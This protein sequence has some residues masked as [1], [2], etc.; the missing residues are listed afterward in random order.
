MGDSS[1]LFV[2]LRKQSSCAIFSCCILLEP[3]KLKSRGDS[4]KLTLVGL[5]KISRNNDGSRE[6]PPRTVQLDSGR[7]VRLS[8]ASGGLVAKRS[9]YPLPTDLCNE[10]P[11]GVRSCGVTHL[12]GHTRDTVSIHMIQPPTWSCVERMG[13]LFT[14]TSS[15]KRG[16]GPGERGLIISFSEG[17]GAGLQG[18]NIE[19]FAQQMRIIM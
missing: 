4:S 11:C 2:G 6:R 16:G 1:A 13:G 5:C 14:S 15:R 10:G 8:L 17:A 3:S 9:G 18:V 7:V 19:I 12:D